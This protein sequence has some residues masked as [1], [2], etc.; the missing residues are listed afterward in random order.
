MRGKIVMYSGSAI[1]KREKLRKTPIHMMV[2]PIERISC[3]KIWLKYFWIAVE[4]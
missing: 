1:V 4:Y 2:T 3:E